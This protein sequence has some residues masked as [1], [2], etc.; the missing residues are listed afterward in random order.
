[1]WARLPGDQNIF[2][3]ITWV[4]YAGPSVP[5][6]HQQVFDTVKAARDKCVETAQNAW[7]RQEPVCGWQLDDAARDV[8]TSAGYR[9]FIRHRTGHSLSPGPKV[10]GLG[11]NIDNLESHD[12][13]ELL[14][15]IGFTVE[16]GLYLPDFGVRLEI[17]CF[18]DEQ[19]GPIVTSCVQNEVVLLV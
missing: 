15:G 17:N 8:L 16:P 1:M 2:S 7:T 13:R 4:A 3:D 6:K 14:S 12:S 19:R 5:S 10:H 18:V 9:E 11:V